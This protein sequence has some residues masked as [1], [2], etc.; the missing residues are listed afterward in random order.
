MILGLRP[1]ERPA[2]RQSEPRPWIP[3]GTLLLRNALDRYGKARSPDEWTGEEISARRDIFSEPQAP[4]DRTIGRLERSLRE[5]AG[6]SILSHADAMAKWEKEKDSLFMEW[7]AEAAARDR[8]F[9]AFSKFRQILYT[10]QVKHGLLAETD[11][12]IIGFRPK[13]WASDKNAHRAMETGQGSIEGENGGC[14][15]GF[16]LVIKKSLESAIAGKVADTGRPTLK[17]EIKSAYM[18]L[19]ADGKIDFDA[20]KKRMYRPVRDR[21]KIDLGKPKQVAGLGDEAIRTHAGPLFD[22][23][24]AERSRPA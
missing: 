3:D 2:V 20:A 5:G 15:E 7:R 14:V 4:V 17:H 9:D 11:G 19:A 6:E 18:A 24:K 21:V 12:G 23:D 16:I 13:F 8:W 10:G 22:K 1:F